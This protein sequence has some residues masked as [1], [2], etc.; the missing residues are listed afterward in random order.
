MSGA[1]DML[2]GDEAASVTPLSV[3]SNTPAKV[4]PGSGYLTT[5]T[6]TAVATG[7]SGGYT[8]KWTY[9]SGDTQPMALTPNAASC[10]WKAYV[11]ANTGGY[12]ASWEVTVT[13]S[14]DSTAT[15]TG[16]GILMIGTG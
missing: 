6:L 8:F 9:V 5:N 16:R 14:S 12:E 13:D 10:A 11:P 1:T 2:Y 15:K 4:G 7:G 3:T